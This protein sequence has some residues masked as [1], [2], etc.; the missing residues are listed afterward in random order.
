MLELSMDLAT[1][2]SGAGKAVLQ[3]DFACQV[4]DAEPAANNKWA[5][6]FKESGMTMDEATNQT[7]ALAVISRHKCLESIAKYRVSFMGTSQNLLRGSI[8][9]LRCSIYTG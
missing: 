9:L 2:R 3:R 4:A 6:A 5:R 7:L 1:A 8:S